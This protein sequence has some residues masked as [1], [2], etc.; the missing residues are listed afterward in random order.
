MSGGSEHARQ[1]NDR[2]NTFLSL[3]GDG[4]AR[5][6]LRPALPVNAP[7]D[8][9]VRHILKHARVSEC[10]ELFA[11]FYGREARQM[12]GLAMGDYVPSDQPARLH[13]IH[14]FIAPATGSCARGRGARLGRGRSRWISASA[15]GVAVNGR[16][17]EFWLCLRE[18]TERKRAELDRERRGRI[19]EAVAFSAARLLQ[20]GVAGAG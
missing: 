7:E 19:L 10:N 9:Q 14:E 20:P 4:V 3:S 18:I 11:G 5:F 1:G 2:Y 16:L 15:L 6:E 17:H 8:E 13:G 12:V